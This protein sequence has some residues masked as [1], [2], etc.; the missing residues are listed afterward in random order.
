M[1]V[2]LPTV[3]VEVV[4]L[5]LMVAVADADGHHQTVQAV[6]AAGHSG[7]GPSRHQARRAVAGAAMAGRQGGIR[8]PAS[9]FL[10]GRSG[11][12]RVPPRGGAG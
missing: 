11:A 7:A 4:V 1:I 2:H 10:Q 6:V 9:P 8:A 3:R 5:P 12:A